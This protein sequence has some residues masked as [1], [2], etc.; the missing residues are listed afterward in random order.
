MGNRAAAGGLQAW[1]IYR[2]VRRSKGR[3]IRPYGNPTATQFIRYKTNWN[4]WHADPQNL[5]PTLRV[6]PRDS[7]FPS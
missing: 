3:H 7:P 5:R 6:K 1:Y 4:P 2:A